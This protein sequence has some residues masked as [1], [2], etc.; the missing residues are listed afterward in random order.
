MTIIWG[1]IH[2]YLGMTINYSFTGKVNFFMVKFIGNMLENIPEDMKGV[3]STPD[4]KHLLDTAEDTTK[5]SQT[6]ADILYYLVAKILYLSKISRSDIQLPVSLLCIRLRDPDTDY[7]NN[8]TR[9]MNYI[10]G[11]IGLPLIPSIDKSVN[12]EWYIDESFAAQKYTRIHIGGLMTMKTGRGLCKIQ[13]KKLRT[14]NSTESELV[15]VDNVLNQVI[16]THYF[17]KDQGY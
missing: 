16:C 17:L 3:F 8:L 15:G 12:I 2:K 10:Q 6:D 4:G 9:V 14:N 13:F 5:L 11:I 1:K 7:Y